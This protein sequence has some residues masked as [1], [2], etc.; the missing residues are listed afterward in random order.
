MLVIYCKQDLLELM[1][2]YNLWIFLKCSVVTEIQFELPSQASRSDIFEFVKTEL[3]DLES[4]LSDTRVVD[5]GRVDKM[6]HLHF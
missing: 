2:T 4:K 6:Q 1:H 3:L 5:Y